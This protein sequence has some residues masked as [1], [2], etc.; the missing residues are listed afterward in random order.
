MS[1]GLAPSSFAKLQDET[2]E[3]RVKVRTSKRL[4]QGKEVHE[5]HL[6]EAALQRDESSSFTSAM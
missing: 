4:L 2:K 5:E 1:V 6:Q 3:R